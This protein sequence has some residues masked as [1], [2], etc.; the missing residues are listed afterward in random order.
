MP[1]VI[2]ETPKGINL[3]IRELQRNNNTLMESDY[4]KRRKGQREN[5][6]QQNKREKKIRKNLKQL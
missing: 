5:Y 4:K 2:A 3:I 6:L 1:T